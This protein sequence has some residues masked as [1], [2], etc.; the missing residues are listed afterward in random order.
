MMIQH[1]TGWQARAFARK[2]PK[3]TRETNHMYLGS[4]LTSRVFV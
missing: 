2:I 4:N 3:F 1:F